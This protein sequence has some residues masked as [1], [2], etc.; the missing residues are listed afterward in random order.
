MV[1]YTPSKKKTGQMRYVEVI[2]I[3]SARNAT[4]KERRVYEDENG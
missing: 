1:A 3:I 4:P 2:R